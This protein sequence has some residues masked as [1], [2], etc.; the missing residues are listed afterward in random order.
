MAALSKAD[1]SL[2][3]LAAVG[4]AFPVTQAVTRP[5]I[6]KEAVLS[7]QIEGTRTSFQ[8]LLYYEAGQLGFFGNLEDTREV[9]NYVQAMDYGLEWLATLPLSVRL[10]RE[11]HA[12]LMQ[13]VRGEGMA[14][15]EI[16]RSQNW[17]GGPGATLAE[18]RYVPPPPEEMHDCLSVL[19]RYI[20][21]GSELPPLIRIGLIHVQFEAIHPFLDGNGRIGR[22]LVT[23]LLDDW[24][25]LSQ[26]LLY[27]SNFIETNGQEYY[28]RL[29]AVSQ[30]EG[31]EDWLMFFLDVVHSQAADASRRIAN[32]QELRAQ[33][34]TQFANDRTRENLSHLVDYLISTPI[35]SISQAQETLELGS[36]TTVQ[37]CVEKLVL[38]GIVR[39]VTG[40]GRNRIY[41]ADQILRILADRS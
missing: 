8:E 28:D 32:L 35:I 2:A 15:G 14:P 1:R 18:A 27:L 34:Q 26:P 5:F 40:K 19:E 7:S 9:K 31:W 13:G 41:Q 6:R 16:R 36:Y 38:Y 24:G 37:R 21:D 25:L 23:L 10:M 4:N 3:R 29:L 22:L 20:H 39:E 11:I 12:I 17:I 30:K 33:Y